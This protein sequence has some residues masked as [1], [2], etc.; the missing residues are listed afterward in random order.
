[1]HKELELGV[2]DL[3]SELEEERLAELLKGLHGV[4]GVR[5]VRGGGVHILYNP[6]GITADELCE[7]VR[8]SGFTVKTRQATGER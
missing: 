5:L 2:E 6:L 1:V 3:E 4:H 7:T 8:R